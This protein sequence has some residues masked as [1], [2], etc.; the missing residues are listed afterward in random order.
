MVSFVSPARVGFPKSNV[1]GAVPDVIAPGSFAVN[2]ADKKIYVGGSGGNPIRFSQW[3]EDWSQAKA[4]RTGDFS[5][6]G[7]DLWRATADITAG[8]V[9]DTAQWDRVT[10]ATRSER[11]EPYASGVV[12]GGTASIATGGTSIDVDSG[13]GVVVDN[14]N[15]DAVTSITVVWAAFQ[16]SPTDLGASESVIGLDGT[17]AISEVTPTGYTSEWRRT[18]V[19]LVSIKWVLGVMQMLTRSSSRVAGMSET[20]LDAYY[21]DD[22]AYRVS[23]LH[24]TPAGGLTMD[25]SA[26]TT[27]AIHDRWAS[28]PYAPNIRDVIA[29][30]PFKF[31]LTSPNGRPGTQVSDIDP[32][33]WFNV[34]SLV[35]VPAGDFTI[36]YVTGRPDMESV[37]VEYG[38]TLYPTASAALSALRADWDAFN[39]Y[40][41]HMLWVLLAAIVVKSGETDLANATII[42]ALR[43]SNPFVGSGDADSATFY[44][45]DGSRPLDGDMDVNGFELTNAEIDGG[46][47]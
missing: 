28:S 39:A 24:L 36:Q 26:G 7:G 4:Y 8:F 12:A 10:N 16:F 15:P 30:T 34:G 31:K 11:S 47:F 14:T 13:S 38:Q 9:F 44:V 37:A 21:A 18:H 41:P 29:E 20:Y 32:G 25:R 17:G 46:S 23:G 1:S 2:W 40:A 42:E 45:L 22:G 5:F 19:E 35:T 33:T 6:S 3:F 27:F 43:G